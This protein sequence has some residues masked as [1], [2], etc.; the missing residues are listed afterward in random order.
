MGSCF[1]LWK[2]HRCYGYIINRDFCTRSQIVCHLIGVCIINLTL[3]RISARCYDISVRPYNILYIIY[4]NAS[5]WK[6][7]CQN[8]LSIRS[9]LYNRYI[10]QLGRRRIWRRGG[11]LLDLKFEFCTSS[12]WKQNIKCLS[13]ARQGVIGRPK[14][15]AFQF[16]KLVY[17]R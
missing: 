2:D 14:D 9:R 15:N 5:E 7:N 1:H 8:F 3:Q 16:L 12:I 4:S 11:Y 13:S 10:T 17:C 6:V